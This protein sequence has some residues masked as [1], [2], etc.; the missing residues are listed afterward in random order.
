MVT[1]STGRGFAQWLKTQLA[2]TGMSRR[3]LA[4]KSGVDHS[5]ISRLVLGQR[6]PTLET[7][8]KLA[9]AL[10]ELRQGLE[11]LP[12]LRGVAARDAHAT[13][14]VEYA[15]R[16]DEALTEAQ[17][18]E[19][20]RHYLAL[21]A[22]TGSAGQDKHPGRDPLARPIAGPTQLRLVSTAA[23]S[24]RAHGAR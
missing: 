22:R 13:S 18:R 8:T 17:V 2:A 21:R 10:P 5:T 3:Q 14:R 4:Q 24:L 12:T 9:G 7:A 16:S 11:S 23:A 6:M 19:L 15:L 1:T 20:M